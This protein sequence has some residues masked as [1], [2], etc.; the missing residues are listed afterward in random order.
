MKNIYNY[1]DYLP[2]E[3]KRNISD[4]SDEREIYRQ[5]YTKNYFIPEKEAP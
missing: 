1:Y 3:V 2:I 4:Y 5:K